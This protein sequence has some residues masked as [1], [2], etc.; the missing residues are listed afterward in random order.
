[1]KKKSL[2]MALSLMAGG[3]LTGCGND[4]SGVDEKQT[5][6]TYALWDADQAAVYQQLANQFEE[7]TNIRVEFQQTPWEQYWT[8][9]EAAI[10]GGEAPDVFWLN[11]PR[12]PDFVEN[13]VLLSLDE[14]DFNED[15]IPEQFLEAYSRDGVLY[16]MSKDFDSHALYYNKTMFDE[17]GFDYPDETWT[18]DDWKEA[19]KI[20]TNADEGIY[21]M[22]SPNQWQAGYY[23]IILQNDGSPFIDK[24]QASGFGE[25]ATI[26]ALEFWYSFVEEGLSPSVEVMAEAGATQ[27]LT[28]GRVAMS[29][30]GSYMMPH[31]FAD[32]YAMENID[33]APLPQGV[34]RATTSNSIAN[35]ISA[36]TENPEAAK[37]W[38]EF[39]STREANEF[40][41]EFGIMPIYEGTQGAWVN[42]FP[43]KNL[44]V[45]V[46]AVEYAI[47]LPGYKNSMAA[48]AI[49]T[50][51]L[52]RAWTGEITVREAS[53]EIEA[54][55]N[56]ILQ[57]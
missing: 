25:E 53:L 42:A 38:I 20:L 27:L 43:N 26:E 22:V 23:N 39:L 44:Q 9:V 48:I 30:E 37:Q 17:A 16:G 57:N 21:G 34:Q 1:M 3:I 40:V 31:I 2:L 8:K 35:V 14:L 19:A 32:D 47:P 10:T 52:N 50:E 11:I 45:H 18:W 28:S 15:A 49:E 5:V 33:V 7:E 29:I 41:A 51:I 56:A 55:A 36:G 54:R 24:G 13:D 4:A 6:I 46:D 12:F